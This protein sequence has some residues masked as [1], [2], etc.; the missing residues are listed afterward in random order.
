M[1]NQTIFAYIAPITPSD[2]NDLANSGI[3]YVGGAGAVKVDLLNGST[4]TIAGL[5]AGTFLPVRVKKV[6]ATGTTATNISVMY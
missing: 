6:H 1:H 3:L 5:T 2:A 4:V